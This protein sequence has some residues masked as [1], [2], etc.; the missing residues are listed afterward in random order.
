[1]AVLAS[2]HASNIVQSWPQWLRWS[3]DL[4]VFPLREPMGRSLVS[5]MVSTHSGEGALCVCWLGI[6]SCWSSHSC[7]HSWSNHCFCCL[8]TSALTTLL[9]LRISAYCGHCVLPS[10]CWCQYSGQWRRQIMA[11]S[12]PVVANAVVDILAQHIGNY[13]GLPWTRMERD[14]ATGLGMFR[15]ASLSSG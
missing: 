11:F 1:M 8:L 15:H 7:Q 2:I 10:H 9:A 5:T 3:A 6:R 12:T 4:H 13:T 14:Q